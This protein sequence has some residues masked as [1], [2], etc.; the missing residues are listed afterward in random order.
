MS[1]SFLSSD[2][3]SPRAAWPAVVARLGIDAATCAFFVIAI[4]LALVAHGGGQ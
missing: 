4:A 3:E 1:H 2:E